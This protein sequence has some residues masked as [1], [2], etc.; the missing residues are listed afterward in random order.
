MCNLRPLTFVIIVLFLSSPLAGLVSDTTDASGGSFSSEGSSREVITV[1]DSGGQ[2]HLTIQAA[3]DGAFLGETILVFPG[4]YEENIVVD[5]QVMVIG[6][7]SAS[8]IIDG[9]GTGNVITVLGSSA[10]IR[11]FTITNGGTFFSGIDLGNASQCTVR[12]CDISGSWYGVLGR[13]SDDNL[14]TNN[15]IHNNTL[16]GIQVRGDDNRITRN[17]CT[18]SDRGVVVTGTGNIILD[19][20]CVLNDV[21]VAVG[22]IS[23]DV[24][25]LGNSYTFANNLDGLVERVIGQTLPYLSTE[26]LTAGGLTLGDHADSAEAP[27]SLWNN[28][29]NQGR[30]WNAL[31]L[32]DQSQIPGFPTT[33]S[34]WRRSLAGARVLNGMAEDIGADTVFLMT[35]GRRDGDSTNPTLYP[36]F[37]VM[38]DRLEAGYGYYAENLS[39]Q[40]RP[41]WIAPVGLAFKHIHDAIV[42]GGGDPTTPGT[43]FY[44]LYS[45]DGSHPALP[46]SYLAACVLYATLMGETPVGLRDSVSISASRKLALQ[47]AAAA[48]VFNKTPG[49]EYHWR[50]SRS[51]RVVEN[52][53]DGNDHGLY[54]G[55]LSDTNTVANNTFSSNVGHAVGIVGAESRDNSIHHNGFRNNNH[56]DIQAFVM[57]SINEWDDGAEG[58]YW[59]D[60]ETRY[61][62][63]TNDGVV[64]DTPYDIAGGGADRY[65]L[66]RFPAFEDHDPPVAFAGA[67]RIE[68][69]DTWVELDGGGSYDEV[70]IVNYT[71]TFGYDGE[72]VVLYGPRVEFR[73]DVPGVYNITLNA[74]DAAGNWDVDH[75]VITIVDTT[76]PI[77][78]ISPIGGPFDQHETLTLDGSRSYDSVGVVNWTW[79]FSYEDR[80]EYLYGEVVE[81]VFDVAGSYLVDLTV[82]DAAGNIGVDNQYFIVLDTDPPNADAGIDVSI[83]QGLFATLDASLSRD[84]V[85]ITTYTWTFEEMGT[86][87]VLDG[88]TLEHQ[89]QYAG[90]YTVTLTV[91]DDA[92]NSANDTLVV[93][94]RDTEPPVAR[95]GEDLT[96]DQLDIFTLDGSNSTDNVGIDRFTGYEWSVVGNDTYTD[97]WITYNMT[98]EE[99]GEYTIILVVRDAAGNEA[100]DTVTITVLDVTY[101]WA[102]PL[103]DMTVDQETEVNLDGSASSD[104]VG[105]VAWTWT[106]TY[107]G[108]ARQLD[109]ETVPFMFDIPGD[110][111]MTFSVT[112]A[113]SLTTEWTFNIRVLDTKPPLPP[114]FEDLEVNTGDRVTM[115]A[116]GAVD[117]IGIV[118]WTWTFEEGG[119][120]VV[121]EGE[122]VEHVFD[123]AGEYEVTLRVEDAEGNSAQESFTVTVKGTNWSFVALV[124]ALVVLMALAVYFM[125]PAKGEES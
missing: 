22:T 96:V 68:D 24:L 9:G 88:E 36:N 58:N 65:P 95:A 54:L 83:D 103:Q 125:R 8:T 16:A 124:I 91:E 57:G 51:N 79:M 18:F 39:T 109:G 60:Y 73:F 47:E 101:P 118:R 10:T 38:Q 90:D 75:V 35:W 66:V 28:T 105:I 11:G 121:L 31:V 12:D 69:E 49:Y 99:V 27:D 50:H 119:R 62:G 56:P 98:F 123:E 20:H 77:G 106:F 117:N 67:D 6:N 120:T 80:I 107:G 52:S 23:L 94:V 81:Y 13:G 21:G 15:T 19:N 5:K 14:L 3:I 46:G 4:T 45:S 41:A 115:I 110:Y 112:D 63:A 92:G 85:G 53:I 59:S 2:D 104:N 33:S 72:T 37:T 34:Y 43:L 48:T 82:F 114:L 32:Q 76:D 29:I 30:P 108:L 1:D 44:D 93:A 7:G 71:W 111:E 84:N 55:L 122:E 26:R 87:V 113:V 89:F 42:A 97:V 70:G 17:R 40:D 116:S 78:W 100:S 61:P 102:V 74:T 25:L 64:W 86:K